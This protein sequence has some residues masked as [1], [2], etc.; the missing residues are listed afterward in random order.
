[1]GKQ[2]KQQETI[3]LGSKITVDSDSNHEIKK[4]KILAPWKKSYDK[5]SQHFKR[6]SHH[7]SD[8]SPSTQSYDFFSSHVWMWVGPQRRLSAKE[9][10]LWTVVLE[11]TLE[12][13]LN[14]K[15]IKAVSP[16]G[17]QPWIFIGRTDAETEAPVLWPP[18][19]KNW[20]FGKDPDDEN[21]WQ[22][23]EKG[24]TEDKMVRCHP[25][26][27]GHKFEQTL[28]DSEGQGSLAHCCKWGQKESDMT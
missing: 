5:H 3:F 7:F 14:N 25:Q 22:Q 8:K 2:W 16:K 10:M 26:L 21:N 19:A 27:N 18:D 4:K 24:M 1:M 12:T 13:P 11:K 15:E 28:G 23:E 17:N 20:L 9:L 6:Q